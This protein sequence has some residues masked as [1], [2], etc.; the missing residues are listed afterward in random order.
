VVRSTWLRGQELVGEQ[1]RGQLIRSGATRHAD[2]RSVHEDVDIH[3][4]A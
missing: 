4:P 2:R 1:N 3:T